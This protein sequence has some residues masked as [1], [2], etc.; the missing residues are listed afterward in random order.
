MFLERSEFLRFPVVEEPEIVLGQACYG[1]ALLV[2]H[3]YIGEH[4][5]RVDLQRIRRLIRRAR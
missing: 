5:P 2:R 3:S 1:I 4:D